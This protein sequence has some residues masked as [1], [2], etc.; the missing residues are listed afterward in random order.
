MVLNEN[1]FSSKYNKYLISSAESPYL[2]M[3]QCIIEPL[4]MDEYS[5]LEEYL[6]H[7][8]TLLE[9]NQLI[10]DLNI[11]IQNRVLHELNWRDFSLL[12]LEDAVGKRNANMF[13]L[14]LHELK[15]III[16]KD[17]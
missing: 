5:S 15:R 10:L 12:D 9:L 1:V 11:F 14:I 7:A 2:N 16:I 8:F 13:L 3:Y 17:F 4:T 6:S